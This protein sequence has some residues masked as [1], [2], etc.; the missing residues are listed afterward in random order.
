MKTL[1]R[2][3]ALVGLGLGGLGLG[4]IDFDDELDRF[5]EGNPVC[6]DGGA[7][8]DGGSDGGG[9]GG[10]DG[11]GDGGSDG[12]DA[13]PNGG[14]DGGDGGPD[15]GD[16]GPDGGSTL[17]SGWHERA[18]LNL[19]RSGHTATL[20]RNGTV[21]VVG[22]LTPDGITSTAEVYDPKTNSWILLKNELAQPRMDHTA[23]LLPNNQ[24]LVVGGLV[25]G[26]TATGT[27]ELY[28]PTTQSWSPASGIP[29]AQRASHA[30]VLLPS[31]K[32]LVTGGGNNP[33]GGL[34]T[35]AVYTS[36]AGWSPSASMKAERNALT[37]TVLGSVAIAVGGYDLNGRHRSAEVFD[38][39]EWRLTATSVPGE[40]REGHTATALS[41]NELLIAGT[42]VT[43]TDAGVGNSAAIYNATSDSWSTVASMQQGRFRHAAARVSTGEVLVTG[44]Y[45]A[46]YRAAHNS[47]ELFDP[48]DRRWHPAKGDMAHPRVGHTCTEM[49]DGTVLVVGGEDPVGETFLD[50]VELY[51]P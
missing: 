35:S 12:G 33:N 15:G 25:D 42:Y 3:V 14:E 48:K 32:V 43:T 46:A 41:E 49:P 8:S 47:A 9:D 23:T 51:V 27:A 50:S 11:G 38:G 17:E 37:L 39:V 36:D 6:Q 19:M 29:A 16:A 45:S 4:C 7:S 26:T 22:G 40:G 31:N 30:A 24:V 28:D 21:L 2:A 1:W 5:C 10:S 18:P 44:G 13:G 20:L 34:A